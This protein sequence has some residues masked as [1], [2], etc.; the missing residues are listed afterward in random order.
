MTKKDTGNT[1]SEVG[2]DVLSVLKSLLTTKD[3]EKLKQGLRDRIEEFKRI[4]KLSPKE[5]RKERAIKASK[6][7]KINKDII[8]LSKKYQVTIREILDERD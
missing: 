1:T 8:S 5:R 6:E 2:R 3:L 7:F 4:K